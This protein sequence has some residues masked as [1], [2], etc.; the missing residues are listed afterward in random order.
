LTVGLAVALILVPLIVLC[1][2]VLIPGK[3]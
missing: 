1:V 3:E 2:T